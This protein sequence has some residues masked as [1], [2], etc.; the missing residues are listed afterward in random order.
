MGK[1]PRKR[2]RKARRSHDI[3]KFAGVYL[4]RHPFNVLDKAKLR[5]ALSKI[6][7]DAVE[8]FDTLVADVQRILDSVD[9]LQAIACLA[10]YGLTATLGK[11]GTSGKTYKGDKFTQAHVELCIALALRTSL[12]KRGTATA[13]AETVQKLFDLLPQIS[14]TFSDKR[15]VQLSSL[16]TDEERSVAMLQEHLRVHTQAVRNWGYFDE[17]VGTV[18]RLISPL[19]GLW[20]R[21]FGLSGSW[22]VRFFRDRVKHME[23]R[24]TERLAFFREI[25]A[26]R[27]LD[28]FLARLFVLFPA[29][30]EYKRAFTK[31]VTSQAPLSRMQR[32]AAAL[33]YSDA[34]V[35]IDFLLSAKEVA[36]NYGVRAE[37]VDACFKQLS[38]SFGE[39]NDVPVDFVLLGNPVWSR[40]LV[41][42][43]KSIYYCAL[44]QGFF[45]FAFQILNEMAAKN[46]HLQQEWAR[47]RAEFLE[48]EIEATFRDAFPTSIVATNYKWKDGDAEYEND[49]LIQVG[50]HLLIIEAKSG[51][52]SWSA[53]RGAP[54]RA[55]K[56]F[57]ELVVEPSIQSLRLKEKI[58]GLTGDSEGAKK[59]FPGFPFNIATIKRVLR[60][61]VTLEDFALLQTNVAMAINAGWVPNGHQ[62]PPTMIL[63][64]LRAVL[65]LLEMRAEKIHYLQ[66]REIIQTTISYVGDEMDLLGLYLANGFDVGSMEGGEVHLVITGMSSPVDEFFQAKTHGIAR[67]RPRR[68]LTKWWRDICTQF[69]QREFEGWTEASTILL[70]VGHD[71]Q[72]KLESKF[73]RVQENVMRRWHEPGHLSSVILIPPKSRSD[74]IVAYAYRDAASN[75][76]R[77]AMESIASQAFEGHQHVNR[78]LVLGMNL[79]KRHYPYSS[80]AVFHR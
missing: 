73:R 69:E 10:T 35:H 9:A 60:L 17:V 32:R 71:D 36:D 41:S 49:V 14:K 39:L 79:D 7:K 43:G 38:I 56:H 68:K 11:D 66:R 31:F 78:C 53:L 45:S 6:G 65:H 47:R 1:H 54:E 59:A 33:Q 19:D 64:D 8:R 23:D 77:N 76:R 63:G 27:T 70:D 3:Q 15:L 13:D 25:D 57:R 24:F 30:D 22:I 67:A 20:Q 29:P 26:A 58:D 42:L 46:T 34:F 72:R 18:G 55:K 37:D 21:T 80:L 74:A 48:G 51:V 2:R 4:A 12:G 16:K 75:E 52:V 28:D 44:P 40:P 50:S 5:D 62:L 61:S